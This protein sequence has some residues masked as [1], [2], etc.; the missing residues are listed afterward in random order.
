MKVWVRK[1]D[2]PHAHAAL[3]PFTHEADHALD[4]HQR[5]GRTNLVM[6]EIH[7]PGVPPG[8]FLEQ[9]RQTWGLTWDQGARRRRG[10]VED[11]S[12]WDQLRQFV[13]AHGGVIEVP[14]RG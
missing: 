5:Q 11:Q 2:V 10:E 9:L 12:G 4:R 6:F 13:A 3:R 14:T 1:Q 8:Q 7:F